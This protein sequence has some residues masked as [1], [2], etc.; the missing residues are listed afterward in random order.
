[1]TFTVFV[2]YKDFFAKGFTFKE[3]TLVS[4]WEQ[5]FFYQVKYLLQFKLVLKYWK[6]EIES[7]FYVKI[8]PFILAE[9]L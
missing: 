1:M 4:I 9:R 6:R 5:E 3:F 7:A 2:L 8:L